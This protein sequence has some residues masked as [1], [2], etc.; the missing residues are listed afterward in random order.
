MELD[1]RRRPG[2]KPNRRHDEPG[3][4][5]RRAAVEVVAAVT[6]RH[7]P[8]DALLDEG[9]PF[10]GLDGADRA[11]ARAIVAVAL[12]RRGQIEAA[13]RGLMERPLPQ[14]AGPM[15]AIL[16]VA[17]AQLLFMAVPDHAAVSLALSLAE[18]DPNARHFK[19]VANG[20]LR[21][22]ARGRDALLATQDAARVNTPDWLWTRWSAA[23]GEATARAIAEAHLGEP[24]LDLTVR[25]DPAAW[26]ERLG[27]A[28]LPT[29]SVRLTDA[30]AVDAL[31]GYGDGA[32]WVQD[33]AAML[34]AKLLGE[35]TGKTA[36][37]L[38]AAPGGKTAQLAAAGAAVTAV[39]I[40]AARLK[41][42]EANLARLGLETETVA[43]DALGYDPGR[44]FD[45]VLL[46]APCSAT[47]TIRRHPDIPW[48]K[49][50]GDLAELAALQARLLDR[51]AALT[52]PGGTLVFATCSLEPEE[53]EAQA[54]A[55]LERLPLA[56]LPLAP[57]EFPGLDAPF[58]TADGW[59]RT[60]PNH[61]PAPEIPGG[62][63]GF[64]AARFRRV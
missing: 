33:V 15:P 57:G 38:C 53:G 9:G 64:F 5:A 39:D 8:L 43:A 21:N 48:L 37:D 62:M 34:P 12:R 25:G 17:A 23:H 41:R 26:A 36:L 40:S 56:P 20:V 31:P 11:L 3:L 59:L 14:R 45:M 58:V 6:L 29:G 7:Q 1:V 22:L 32:W 44:T 28:L 27:G 16:H 50:E 35:V 63:D 24:P 10:G 60:L 54:K 61:A 2:A 30:G 51:A 52:K 4:A 49:R 47:G 13:L 19:A 18:R 46:D 55:A 42:V